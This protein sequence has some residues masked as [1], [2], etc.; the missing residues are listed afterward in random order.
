MQ[1]LR[2][3]IAHDRAWQ[4]PPTGISSRP[5][6]PSADFHRGGAI[7][8]SSTRWKGARRMDAIR[9]ALSSFGGPLSDCARFTRSGFSIGGP[10]ATIFLSTGLV[11]VPAWARNIRGNRGCDSWM[12]FGAKRRFF[13]SSRYTAHVGRSSGHT[14]MLAVLAVERETQPVRNSV[15]NFTGDSG[16]AGRVDGIPRWTIV[17]WR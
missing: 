5:I 2:A 4:T 6:A 17:A 15:R 12:V 11:R 8:V 10:E 7:G 16:N 9:R 1:L 3:T 14:H 13:R